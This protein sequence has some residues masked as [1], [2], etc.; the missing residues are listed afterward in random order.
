M[1]KITQTLVFILSFFWI[2]N[3]VFAQETKTSSSDNNLKEKMYNELK[4]K[5]NRYT[6]KDFDD[7]FFDFLQKQSS[8]KIILTKQEYY[9]YTLSI[10][11]YSAKLGLLYK[12]QKATS[13]KTKQEWYDKNYQDYL[14]TKQNKK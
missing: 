1:R 3:I 12:D 9:N 14:N 8:D 13:E 4:P 7:L 5:V 11:V 2:T 10:A 6:K